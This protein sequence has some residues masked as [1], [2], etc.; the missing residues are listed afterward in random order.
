[1]QAISWNDS[2]SLGVKSLDEQH[3]VWVERLNSLTAAIE[4]HQEARLIT[5]T[6]DFMMDYVEF[7]FSAEESLMANKSYPG[8]AQ[9]KAEH[10]QFRNTLMD[11]FVLEVEE[12]NAVDKIADSINNFQI[13]WLKNHIQQTDKQFADFLNE[14]NA[15]PRMSPERPFLTGPP[16]SNYF[17]PELQG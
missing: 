16:V 4:S 14:Q 11:L 12:D 17:R 9:H 8:L 1:M 15:A 13:S 2:F 7:H 10:R 5:K 6:L 3:R